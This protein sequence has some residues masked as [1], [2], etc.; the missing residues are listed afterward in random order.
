MRVP[1]PQN[2]PAARLVPKDGADRRAI[3][4]GQAADGAR[5]AG[6]VAAGTAKVLAVWALCGAAVVAIGAGMSSRSRSTNSSDEM[7]RRL[8]NLRKMNETPRQMPKLHLGDYY[9]LR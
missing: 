7:N 5:K 8:D 3:L 1:D 4:R 9:N 6:R 2:L